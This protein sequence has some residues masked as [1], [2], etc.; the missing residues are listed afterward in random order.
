MEHE[1]TGLWNIPGGVPEPDELIGRD[2]LIDVLWNLLT[3]NNLLLIAP[4]RFGKT[5]VMRHILKKPRPGYHVVYMEVED[6]STPENFAAE[7]IATLLEN[8][9][10]RKFFS[11]LK[12]ICPFSPH[13]HD[14]TAEFMP[15][16]SRVL[17]NV[18][19]HTFMVA[20]L[21]GSFIG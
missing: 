9:K 13:F 14:F 5:G 10:I 2:H 7:L 8:D 21:F 11:G 4:R 16:H 19:G 6:V 1:N 3:G 20:A 17:R 12:L 15:D 18:I